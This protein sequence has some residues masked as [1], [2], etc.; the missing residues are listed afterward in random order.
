MI[1][2]E[3]DNVKLLS[4]IESAKKSILLQKDVDY[5][6]ENDNII[7]IDKDTGQR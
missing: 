3:L 5:I 6:N 1:Y 2:K 4:L 7:I